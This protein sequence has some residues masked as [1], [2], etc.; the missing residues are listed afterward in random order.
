M[1]YQQDYGTQHFDVYRSGLSY[2]PDPDAKD[3]TYFSYSLAE[4]PV[5]ESWGQGLVVNHNPN[6]LFPLPKDFFP[7][8]VQGYIENGEH[9]VDGSGWHPIMSRT[10]IVDLGNTGSP[11][12]KIP[13]V[14][15]TAISKSAF[16]D[17]C[18]IAFG[19]SNPILMEDGWFIDETEKFLGVVVRDKID[20]DWGYIILARDEHF[21]FRAIES[22]HS[23]PTRDTARGDLQLAIAKLVCSGQ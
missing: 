13:R 19:D 15:V 1:G 9:K 22:A 3:P 16:Q 6:A 17:M 12:L 4:P 23:K 5:V 10:H 20:Q 2:N 7:E 8:A 21:Q 18:G 11:P 14:Y